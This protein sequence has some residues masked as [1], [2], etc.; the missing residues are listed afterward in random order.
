MAL[1]FGALGLIW[2]MHR[3]RQCFVCDGQ[4]GSGRTMNTNPNKTE[5]TTLGRSQKVSK[6]PKRLEPYLEPTAFEATESPQSVPFAFP[7]RLG[8]LSCA[9][10]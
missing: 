6:D 3:Q 4:N 10:S 8:P 5:Q 2:Q 1:R 9:V 7:D